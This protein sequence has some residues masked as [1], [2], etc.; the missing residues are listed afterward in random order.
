MHHRAVEDAS[1]IREAFHDEHPLEGV[2]RVAA[3]RQVDGRSGPGR[4]RCPRGLRI[5]DQA[6][7]G[8]L[9][10]VPH[11]RREQASGVGIATSARVVLRIG[12]HH[13][14]RGGGRHPDGGHHGL[15]GRHEC[16]APQGLAVEQV[17]VQRIDDA[18]QLDS[19]HAVAPDR[20]A[21]LGEVCGGEPRCERQRQDATALCLAQALV[22]TER[23][24]NHRAHPVDRNEERQAARG[25]GHRR[26]CRHEVNQ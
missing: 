8:A 1:T 21:A 14:F 16:R 13:G 2:T 5:V 26:R 22:E 10:V 3:D 4:M 20:R 12:N 23:W 7:R 25:F 15:I 17:L 18:I 6:D 9:C 19:V 24:L 11:Q